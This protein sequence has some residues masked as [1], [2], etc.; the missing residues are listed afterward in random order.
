MGRATWL[1]GLRLTRRVTDRE[2]RA[3]F[4]GLT[5]LTRQRARLAELRSRGL[6][7]AQVPSVVLAEAI[8]GDHRRDFYTNRLLK[9]CQIRDVNEP[10]AR[11]AAYGDWSSGQSSA[12]PATLCPC[13]GGSVAALSG[14]VSGQP[15]R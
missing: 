4:G 3:A 2:R 6:W 8:T 5:A 13:G 11:E 10:Q 15:G 9:A 7:P 1:R 12:K 14:R